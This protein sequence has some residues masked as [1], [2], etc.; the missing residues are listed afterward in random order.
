MTDKSALKFYAKFNTYISEPIT[1]NPLIDQIDNSTL[2]AFFRCNS[3]TSC[4]WRKN[5]IDKDVNPDHDVHF[6]SYLHEKH[7]LID[8]VSYLGYSRE[9]QEQQKSPMFRSEGVI[10][11]EAVD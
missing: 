4:L 9:G 11:N 10:Q 8:M 2:I 5:I 1:E 6:C 7:N 3:C